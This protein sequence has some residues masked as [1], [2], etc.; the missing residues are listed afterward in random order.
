MGKNDRE[1]MLEA[2]R[3]IEDLAAWHYDPEADPLDTS[4][5]DKVAHVNGLIVQICKEFTEAE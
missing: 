3:D 4:P 5:E 1:K 2:L